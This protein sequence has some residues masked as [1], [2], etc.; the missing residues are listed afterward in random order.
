MNTP[1]CPGVCRTK[2]QPVN[3]Q[4]FYAQAA[5][6]E[7]IETL[8]NDLDYFQ[9]GLTDQQRTRNEIAEIFDRIIKDIQ[10]NR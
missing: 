10:V 2:W 1:Q 6:M 8:T 7:R 9:R 4:T 5:E 3:W